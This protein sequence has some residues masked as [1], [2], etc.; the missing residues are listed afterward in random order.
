MKGK[1]LCLVLVLVLI[2]PGL[3][4]SAIV[5]NF[6][7]GTLDGWTKS[8]DGSITNPGS[9]GNPGGFLQATDPATGP[10]TWGIAPSKFL[11]DWS[12]YDN[13]G[14]ISFDMIVLSGGSPT[15]EKPNVYISGPG[16]SASTFAN[17]KVSSTWKTFVFPIIESNWEIK[18]G[19]WDNLLTN[20]TMLKID[21]EQ[22]Q[23]KEVTGIDNVTLSQVPIPP[24]LLLL[25]S[26]LISLLGF[27]KKYNFS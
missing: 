3:C 20:V 12:Q 23:G 1:L 16:G 10:N 25:S 7:D 2:V 18:S 8:G 24:S 14:F 6:D 22:I 4:F 21:L 5:S 9:G 13:T 26:A 17:T 19:S 15:T 27:R 11:G